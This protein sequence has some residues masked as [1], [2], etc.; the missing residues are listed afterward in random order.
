MYA[1]AGALHRAYRLIEVET[2]YDVLTR[3]VPLSS[4]QGHEIYAAFTVCSSYLLICLAIPLPRSLYDAIET[5]LYVVLLNGNVAAA[6]AASCG[7]FRRPLLTS[8]PPSP[9]CR[10]ASELAIHT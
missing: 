5:A 7:V 6:W 2:G 3:S 4:W 9:L 10:R 1:N 8:W